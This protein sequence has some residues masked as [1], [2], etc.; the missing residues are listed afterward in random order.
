MSDE[1]KGVAVHEDR[2]PEHAP[3]DTLY[4]IPLQGEDTKPRAAPLEL[5]M[6]FLETSAHSLRSLPSMSSVTAPWS[7]GDMDQE[8]SI[9]NRRCLI[10]SVTLALPFTGAVGVA[11]LF[12]SYVRQVVSPL[13]QHTYGENGPCLAAGCLLS[14]I[15]SALQ[16]IFSP[17]HAG[18]STCLLYRAS[19]CSR[20][21]RACSSCGS[22]AW[23]SGR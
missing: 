15:L 3:T 22:S 12:G 17:C 7:P 4:D 8:L 1:A 10:S 2:P 14:F 23:C 20:C 13:H 16:D 5:D 9:A 11:L 6:S 21:C 19:V 18:H